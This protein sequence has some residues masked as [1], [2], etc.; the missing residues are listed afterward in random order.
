MM[1]SQDGK[2]TAASSKNTNHIDLA[3]IAFNEDIDDNDGN[4]DS[5]MDKND[6]DYNLE[7][8]NGD[9]DGDVNCNTSCY[10]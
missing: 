3:T 9:K 6:D 8:I 4:H 7:A 5:N 1:M 10:K 2:K